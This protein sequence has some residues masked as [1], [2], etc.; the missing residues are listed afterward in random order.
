MQEMG[1]NSWASFYFSV[2]VQFGLVEK[3]QWLSLQGGG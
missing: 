3:E 2:E 1:R